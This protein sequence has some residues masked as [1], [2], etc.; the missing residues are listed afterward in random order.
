MGD[1]LLRLGVYYLFSSPR[2]R[3]RDGGALLGGGRDVGDEEGVLRAV[4][5]QARRGHEGG[6]APG[7]SRVRGVS[8]L[9][10]AGLALA[11]CGQD[12]KPA[13]KAESAIAATAPSAAQRGTAGDPGKGRQVWLG[14]CVSCHN[15]DPA[16]D[17][18]VG[19]AV[20][21]SSVPLLEARLLHASYPP[22]YQ[23]KRATNVMP[24]RPDLAASTPDLAAYLR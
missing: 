12:E 15:I 8:A 4:H 23:P 9:L 13:P 16:K 19:P 14:Q 11:A 1:F 22:G 17:G 20:K 2:E 10:A 24:A 5:E 6:I 7:P 3:G 21:G 18:P